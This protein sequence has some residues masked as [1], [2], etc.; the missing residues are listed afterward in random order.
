MVAQKSEMKRGHAQHF[1]PKKKPVRGLSQL[2]TFCLTLALMCSLAALVAKDSVLNQSFT[3]KQIVTTK[4]VTAVHKGLSATLNSFI[5]EANSQFK[6]S[7]SLITT[8]QVQEDMNQV[9]ANIYSSKKPLAPKKV[10]DQVTTNLVLQAKKRGVSLQSEEWLSY[11]SNFVA[12]VQ[13]AISNQLNNTSFQKGRAHLQKAQKIVPAL[14]VLTIVL[15]VVLGILLLLQTRSLFAFAHYSGI[16]LLI[17]GIVAWL[18]AQLLKLSALV[19]NLAASVG[20]YQSLLVNYG[21]S[22]LNVLSN[23]ASLYGY[24]GIFLL[25]IALCGRVIKLRK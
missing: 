1:G 25:A 19:E 16:A 3:K 21:R 7:G 23:D 10:V 2:L 20:M 14:Y 18:L 13:V 12:Q 17:T 4:N 24:A 5:N 15:S 22:V 11:K 6:F 8:D 9:I